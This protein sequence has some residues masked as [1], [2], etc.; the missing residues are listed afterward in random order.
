MNQFSREWVFWAAVAVCALAESAIILSSIRSLRQAD[1]R[2]A[3]RET[4]WAVLPAIALAWLLTATWAEVRRGGAHEQM[5]MPMPA[6][7][8]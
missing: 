4:M 8:T 7:H 5:S 1:G 6:S 3:V 2:S